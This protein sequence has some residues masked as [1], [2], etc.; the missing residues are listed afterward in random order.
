MTRVGAV[1]IWPMWKVQVLAICWAALSR[2]APSSTT[3]APLPPSSVMIRLN[4]VAAASE[5]IRPTRLL[6]VK[7]TMVTSGDA[8]SASPTSGV[9]PSTRLTTPGGKPASLNALI[10]SMTPR[11]SWW[12]GLTMTVL[13]VTRAGAILPT[14]LLSGTL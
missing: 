5:I 6:P 9:D 12:A 8:T 2:S 14:T 11:G 7:L 13:P 10:I 1:Q 3:A 4:P